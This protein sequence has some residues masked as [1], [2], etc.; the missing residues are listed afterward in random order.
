[1]A[2]SE[3]ELLY[4]LALGYVGEY[5]VTEGNTTEKQYQLCDR[6]YA[7]A[8]DKVLSM[9][10]W[11]EAKTRTMIMQETTAPLFGLTYSFAL[12]SDNLRVLSIGE[13][14]YDWEVEGQYIYADYAKS[15]PTW[16]TATDYVVGQ[17]VDTGSL[18]YLCNTTH[19]SGT[20]ATDLASAYWT[21]QGDEYKILEVEYM[22]QLTDITKFS[23]KLKNAIALYLATLIVT[24]ITNNPQNKKLLVEE[25]VSM[26][27]PEARSIDSMQGKPKPMFNSSWLRSRHSF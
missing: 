26:I 13:T 17:Y 9:H 6:Y 5:E 27:M 2:L 12:P 16:A 23:A 1:M 3:T 19:T 25:F 14:K 15:P 4:N 20:F 7:M 18:T 22:K 24:P 10:P 8:R 11:N 21:S